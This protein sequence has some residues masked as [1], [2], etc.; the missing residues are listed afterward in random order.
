MGLPAT[1]LEPGNGILAGESSESVANPTLSLFEVLL[2]EPLVLG[3]WVILKVT[4]LVSVG[5]GVPRFEV[6]IAA[7]ACAA[8]SRFSARVLRIRG[9]L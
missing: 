8:A 2:F 5:V 1:G 7:F 4:A 3:V 6:L 9:R